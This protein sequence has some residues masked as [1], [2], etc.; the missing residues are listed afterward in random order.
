MSK[1]RAYQLAAGDFSERRQWSDSIFSQMNLPGM[2]PCCMGFTTL[3]NGIVILFAMI[4]VSSLVSV[5]MRDIGYQ[6]LGYD[7]S[8]L[9]LKRRQTFNLFASGMKPPRLG[10]SLRTSRKHSMFWGTRAR[11]ASYGMPSGPGARFLCLCVRTFLSS[12]TGMSLSMPSVGR[13]P[14]CTK[15]DAAIIRAIVVLQSRVF[16]SDVNKS[17]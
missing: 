10:A 1:S 14:A 3:D 2:K 13:G 4:E 7:F 12:S 9:F 15:G 8:L 11:Y 17:T 16:L 5:L 6:F